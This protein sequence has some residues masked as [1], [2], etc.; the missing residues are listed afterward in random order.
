MWPTSF[1]A[2]FCDQDKCPPESFETRVFWR[3]LHR[4]ALPLSA[5]VYLVNREFFELDFRTIRQLGVATSFEEFGA[6]VHSLRSENR[7]HEGFLRRTLR[8]RV[9]GR[10]LM[11]LALALPSDKPVARTRESAASGIDH[12][13]I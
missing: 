3:C 6:E 10:R 1:Q 8:V 13:L 5:L 9:S 2:A 11:D 4:R 7:R 12:T